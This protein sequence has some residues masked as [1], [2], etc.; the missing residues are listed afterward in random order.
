M[1]AAIVERFEL[2]SAR[3]ADLVAGAS[4]FPS[5]IADCT[6]FALDANSADREDLSIALLEPLSSQ[7]SRAPRVWQLLGLSYRH[8]Q[9]MEAAVTAFDTAVA[10]APGDPLIVLAQAQCHFETGRPAAH[11]FRQ[12]QRL[13]PNNVEIVRNAAA[14]LAAEGNYSTGEKLLARAVS[15]N[16]AWLDGHQ[17]LVNLRLTH[18]DIEDFARS[19]RDATR[20]QPQNQSVWL[21]WFYALATR[22]D[23]DKAAAILDEAETAC[24]PSPLFRVR[25]LYLASESGQAAQDPD[26]F[27]DVADQHDPA[28]DICRVRHALRGGWI[29]QAESIAMHYVGTPAQAAFWPYLSLIWRLQKDPRAA[30]LDGEAAYIRQF[31]L[32]ITREELDQLATVL[33]RLHTMQAPFPGQSVRGGTQTDQQLFF[34][35]APEIQRL[36]AMISAVVADY[37]AALP[38]PVEGHPLLGRPRGELRFEGSWSV[39]LSG[40]GF[41]VCHTH[42]HGWISSAFYV[43]LPEK[44]GES[45][46]GWIE[47]GTPPPELG[48]NLPAY[49]RIEPKPGR[50]VLFPSTM[51]HCT[52]PFEDGE[53]LTVA[54]DVA[55]PRR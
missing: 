22:R 24:G 47:F 38:P 15:A 54:F 17:S 40:T 27:N 51:W 45:P 28:M 2:L 10:L 36:R 43:S 6:D 26:L 48:L 37:I 49:T 41:H 21:A 18:G 53:R 33:R 55:S 7:V 8:A 19:Y 16:P 13:A 4:V 42:T 25:R 50:L 46:S 20:A 14:A 12:A 32:D 1:S 52:V 39:R 31:D 3:V 23:W 34:H 30:W 9:N 5:D 11:L 29:D 35:H 44:M